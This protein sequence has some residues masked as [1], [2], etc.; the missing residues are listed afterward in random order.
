MIARLDGFR[1]EYQVYP[2]W[3]SQEN[4]PWQGHG[5][6]VSDAGSAVPF[7]SVDDNFWMSLIDAQSQIPAELGTPSSPSDGQDGTPPSTP[8]QKP[9]ADNIQDH[10]YTPITPLTT[11]PTFDGASL[12]TPIPLDFSTALVG[13]APFQS[14]QSI[15]HDDLSVFLPPHGQAPSTPP[16]SLSLMDHETSPI[17]PPSPFPLR[18][19]DSKRSRRRKAAIPRV[20]RCDV[21]GCTVSF[22]SSRRDIERH[23]ASVHGPPIVLE[24]GESLSYRPDNIA[25]HRKKC[26][27]CS[28]AHM[29]KCEEEGLEPKPRPGRKR[30]VPLDTMSD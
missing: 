16:G 15:S 14:P 10:I 29:R 6:P 5:V 8:A 3:E 20:Y 13:L 28:I 11:S 25:R 26:D 1:M 23:K 4:G 9:P 19:M 30:K 7:T 22:T 18:T 2:P 21:D 17:E 12:F 24:C 27:A